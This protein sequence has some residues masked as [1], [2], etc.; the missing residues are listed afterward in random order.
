[1][2]TLPP[3]VIQVAGLLMGVFFVVFWVFT[4]RVELSLIGFAGTLVG[5]GTV[6]RARQDLKGEDAD[7]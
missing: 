3:W 1:M 7:E 6:A 2:N 4:G 5:A